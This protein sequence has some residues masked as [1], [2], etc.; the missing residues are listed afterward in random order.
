MKYL[1]IITMVKSRRFLFFCV[2]ILFALLMTIL[3]SDA[4][5]TKVQNYVLFLL[6]FAISLWVTEA[7][8]PFSVSILIVGF[9]VFVMG[10]SEAYDAIQYLQTWSDSVIW[11]FLGGFFLAEAMKKTK[12]D[13]LLLKAVLPKFGNNPVYVLWGLMLVTAIMSMLMSNTATTAMMI[14]T[15]SPLFTRLNE[16]SNL[17]KALLLGIP[18]AASVGGMGT[19][20][21]SAPN[22]IAVGAL[23]KLGHPIS[24]L[25]WMMVG[26]PLALILLFIFWRVLVKKYEINKTE[27]LDFSFLQET[28]AIHSNRVEF[29]HKIIVLVILAVTLF[30]WLMSKWIGIPVAA[31]SGIPIVGLTITGVLS[32]KDIRQL[33]WDTLM[34]VAGGLALGLAIEEQRIAAHF[35]EQI[36]HIQVSF[37]MLL[38]LFGFITVILSNFMSNTAATTILI[39]MGVSLLAMVGGNDIHP[40]ILPLVIGLS[41]SCALFLPVSTPPNAIAFSTGLIKQSEFRLGGVI[42]GFLGPILSMLWILAISPLL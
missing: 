26:T 11:L 1:Q 13:L 31:A 27:S 5:F 38:S 41:A 25:E 35:V 33:P 40:M 14:A 12:L 7:I 30:C 3:L 36:S 4:S 24:F 2:S 23:E 32:E 8:P 9:L 18:A 16:S 20:I 21:G 29:L 10:K 17:S 34:L 28:P 15:I 22:A 19:I 6:F 37:I 42:I 39:P